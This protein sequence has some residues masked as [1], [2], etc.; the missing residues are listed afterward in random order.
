MEMILR[1]IVLVGIACS[2][3]PL[4]ALGASARAED[5]KEPK[6]GTKDIPVLS[7]PLA[8]VVTG[9]GR[10][11][12]YSAANLRCPMP[13]VFFVPRD[14]LIAYAQSDDGWVIRDVFEPQ[15]GQYRIRLGAIRTLESGGHRWP[16]TVSVAAGCGKPVWRKLAKDADP[17]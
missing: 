1:K 3:T 6:T 7:P 9:A 15:D 8:N 11:Q 2:V 5:C 10:L 13:G 16:K 12:F 4:V 14:Q 17:R